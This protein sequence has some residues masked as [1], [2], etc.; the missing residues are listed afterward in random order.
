[1]A[2]TEVGYVSMRMGYEGV[3]AWYPSFSVLSVSS[4]TPV[5]KKTESGQED[6]RSEY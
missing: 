4:V 1:M 3:S 6:R 5:E 2:T